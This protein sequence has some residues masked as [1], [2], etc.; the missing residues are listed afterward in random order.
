MK[1]LLVLELKQMGRKHLGIVWSDGHHS[2]YNVRDLRLQCRCAV[3]IDEWTQEKILKDETVP[4]D[5]KPI[6][7]ESVGRYALRFDWSDG[8]GTGIYTFEHLRSWCECPQ[9][10]TH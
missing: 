3:C 1:D 8:H 10:K 7:I 5:V 9:C 6:H 4:A 2:L